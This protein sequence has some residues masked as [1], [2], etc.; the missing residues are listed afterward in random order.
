[1][2]DNIFVYHQLET[3]PVSILESDEVIL[4]YIVKV[5]KPSQLK[6]GKYLCLGEEP[7]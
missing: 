4:L 6:K 7:Q 5:K 1:M 3:L 2:S